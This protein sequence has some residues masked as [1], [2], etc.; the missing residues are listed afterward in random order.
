VIRNDA[1]INAIRSLNFTFKRQTDRVD[2][3][4]K[5]GSTLRVAIRRN[6]LHDEAYTRT[7][8]FQAGMSQSEVDKFIRECSLKRN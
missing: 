6:Q 8:L 5:R 3:Y 2:L 4:R 7:L 1:L